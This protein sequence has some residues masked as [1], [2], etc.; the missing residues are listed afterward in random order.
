MT[1]TCTLV[2]KLIA[3]LLLALT[4]KLFF[5]VTFFL[6]VIPH[7]CIADL[8]WVRFSRHQSAQMSAWSSVERFPSG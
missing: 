1:K 6:K 7:Y 8:Y 4:K 3:M 5:E 2:A